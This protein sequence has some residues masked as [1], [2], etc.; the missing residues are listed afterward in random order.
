M[1]DL[2]PVPTL[3]AACPA[4]GA[5]LRAVAPFVSG[6]F[7]C[8]DAV[9][10]GCGRR[11]YA[12]LDV[13]Y[14]AG[15]SAMFD[16]AEARVVGPLAGE[17][18]ERAMGDA[19]RR[20]DP[21]IPAVKVERLRP[22][23]APILV[24]CVDFL[25]GHTLQKLFDVPR[26]VAENPDRDVVVLVQRAQR[27]LVPDGV[28]EIWTVDLPL[29]DGA[30]CYPKLAASIARRLARRGRA[31]VAGRVWS[32]S[33]DIAAFTRVAPFDLDSTAALGPPVVTL[34]W[35]EDRC[36]TYGGQDR[37]PPTDAIEQ[38]MLFTQLCA[39]IRAGLPDADIAVAGFGVTG[40]LPGGV[41]DLRIAPGAPVDEKAWLRR[42]AASHV[43]CGVHGSGMLLPA[44]HAAA[45]VELMPRD[46]WRHAGATYEFVARKTPMHVLRHSRHVP[47]SI[48][49]DELAT[50]VTALARGVQSTA[51]ARHLAAP[52]V[53]TAAVLAR[54]GHLRELLDPVV[55]D[56]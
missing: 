10:S 55:G 23:R 47:V 42:Y 8:A 32:H 39:A 16:R 53:D 21:R 50:V 56:M 1:I 35:R 51:L 40:V 52:D 25:Y 38:A 31:S 36:W 20:P 27:W 13:G 30:R 46:K 18:F 19:L 4:C 6:M 26:I 43:V 15:R 17:W 11:Y 29:R 2:H 9:C 34:I 33:V 41:A 12:H 49:V 5:A 44:A 14:G 7:V 22:V 48:R 3:D 54:H 45:F 24:D 37:P 28:A